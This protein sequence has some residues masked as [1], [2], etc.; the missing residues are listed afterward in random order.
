MQ[1]EQFP[2]SAKILYQHEFLS[3]AI[4]LCVDDELPVCGGTQS[5]LSR[6]IDFG[7]IA[8]ATAAEIEPS[9]TPLFLRYEVDATLRYGEIAPKVD[10]R[11]NLHFL[12][13]SGRDSPNAI[14][15]R[16]ASIIKRFPSQ[17]SSAA[18]PPL[19]VN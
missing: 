3:F 10:S 19:V 18:N 4:G 8:H 9:D 7:E 5:E 17:D 15:G 13:P 11:D 6:L 2:S 14:A 12:A 1:K 16:A